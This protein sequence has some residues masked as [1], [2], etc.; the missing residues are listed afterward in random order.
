MVEEFFAACFESPPRLCCFH[1]NILKPSPEKEWNVTCLK[2]ISKSLILPRAVL[3]I[4][5]FV[6]I[7]R[8][9]MCSQDLGLVQC[10]WLQFLNHH[11]QSK[12]STFRHSIK[13]SFNHINPHFHCRL[14]LSITIDAQLTVLE[15]SSTPFSNHAKPLILKHYWQ[16]SPLSTITKR[17][18][19][20]INHCVGH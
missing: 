18:K 10:A 11:Q 5:S 9:L 19:I 16:H 15:P 3:W 7:S 14:W 2:P 6:Q 4:G 12:S 20:L 17:D 13:P 8:R 1:W